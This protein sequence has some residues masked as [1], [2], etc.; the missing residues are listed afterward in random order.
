MDTETGHLILMYLTLSPILI[1]SVVH[2]I[3]LIIE[4]FKR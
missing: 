4:I 2:L 3:G 1:I